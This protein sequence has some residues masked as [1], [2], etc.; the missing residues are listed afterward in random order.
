MTREGLDGYPYLK[1]LIH[2]CPGDWVSRWQ[3]RMNRLVRRIVL[4]LVGEGNISFVLS[5]VNGY[6]NMLVALYWK[7]H[8]G[9]KDT[10]FRVK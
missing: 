4:R 8:M 3:K 9:R 1:H 7:V 5:E 6:G 10:R 2:L